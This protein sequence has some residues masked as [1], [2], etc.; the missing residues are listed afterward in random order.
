[1]RV[2]KETPDMPVLLQSSNPGYAGKTQNIGASFLNK[3]SGDLSR[4]L[5]GF[6]QRYFGFGDFIFSD[7]YGHEIAR[8]SDLQTMLKI[9]KTIPAKSI[10]YHASR[11]HFSKWLFART[12]FEIAYHIRPKKISEFKD[13]EEIRKY[14]IE[15]LH[16]FIYRTQLGSV[17]KFDRRLYDSSTPFVKIGSGSIGGKARGLAFMDFLISKDVIP[18]K[19]DGVKITTPNSVV[20]STD[21]FDF[22]MEQNDLESII[23]D[24]YEDERI[25]DIFSRIRLPDYAVNDLMV[26]LDKFGGPIAVRSSSILEDSK[27]HPFAGIYKTYMLKNTGEDLSARFGELEKAVKFIYASVFSKEARAF[28]KMTP[29]IPDEEK[30]AVVVQKIVG[31][32]YLKDRYYPLISGVMQSYNYY[33]VLPLKSSD[34]V[35]HICAGLGESI[36]SGFNALRYSPNFPENLHQFST[37]ENTLLNSQK[38]IICVDLSPKEGSG[39][40][41][42]KE[43][44]IMQI[45]FDELKNSPGFEFL[46]STYS[47]EEEKLYDTVHAEGIK[48]L[49]FAPV[50]KNEFLPLNK[51]LRE[52]SR[53]TSDAMGSNIEMEFALDYNP[54]DGETEF[55]ILQIRPMSSKS[56]MKKVNFH[57]TENK[58]KIFSSDSAL[59]NGYINDIRDIV[60]VKPENFSNL[61]TEA[62]SDEIN[63]VNEKLRNLKWNYALLGPGR[64]GS[65]DIHLGIPVKWN[66]ISFSKIIIEAK[67]DNFWV[68][69]SYGTHFFHNVTSLGIGYLTMLGRN[70]FINW[71][72]LKKQKVYFETE[73]VAHIRLEKALDIRI[74]GNISKAV[75]FY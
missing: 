69:P 44:D 55:N 12:E 74:D 43:P 67:Y 19:I 18:E 58:T 40:E 6:I 64:W 3:N 52:L 21:V 50:L 27:T 57:N 33:P 31:R 11:N 46:A 70:D 65:S 20:L 68:D 8:A 48:L 34:P 37:V 29:N 41:Y 51:I 32:E 35:A 62:I 45:D 28:R 14:L 7:D 71:E 59:G 42:D 73:H 13:G 47:R 56:A 72:W 4:Q 39:I 10:I 2:K 53:I 26:M 9:L 36:V 63:A 1:E 30:M 66:N 49:T 23:N 61:K 38:K 16:Q 5:R 54:Q 75:I 60:C 15:T 24:N 17:L 22:F 25:A